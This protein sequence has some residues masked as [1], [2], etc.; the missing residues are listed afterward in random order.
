VEKDEFF[1]FFP[2]AEGS[3]KG[4]AGLS[5][6]KGDLNFVQAYSKRRRSTYVFVIINVMQINCRK[7][8]KWK[9]KEYAI[10]L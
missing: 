6:E 9:E 3:E 1:L 7:F 8:R 5:K 4:E 2:N 10:L